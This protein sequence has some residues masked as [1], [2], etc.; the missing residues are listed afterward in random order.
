MLTPVMFWLKVFVPSVHDTSKEVTGTVAWFKT[1]ISTCKGNPT[2]YF[3]REI[4][5]GVGSFLPVT[6]LD[7]ERSSPT[8]GSNITTLSI[9]HPYIQAPSSLY[10]N[11]TFTSLFPTSDV[12]FAYS[13]C[14]P[15]AP[16]IVATSVQVTPPSV[17]AT[18][19]AVSVEP[20]Y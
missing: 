14:Q 17:E 11:P 7:T 5:A 6:I 12:R 2:I 15:L 13:V 3:V 1:V 16:G 19:F 18:I 10:L 20:L 4:N 8:A 9:H